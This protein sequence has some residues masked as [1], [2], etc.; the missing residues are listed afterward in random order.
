VEAGGLTDAAAPGR[1]GRRVR[2]GRGGATRQAGG[3]KGGRTEGVLDE[4]RFIARSGQAVTPRLG[5]RSVAAA[6]RRGA[7][8]EAGLG[9]GFWRETSAGAPKTQKIPGSHG[10][11]G[12]HPSRAP[13]RS[14][15]PVLFFDNLCSTPTRPLPQAFKHGPHAL[16]PRPLFAGRSSRQHPDPIPR[17]HR[18]TGVRRPATAPAHPRASEREPASPWFPARA[19]PE[20][21]T[22][23]E[24]CPS[25][26]ISDQLVPVIPAATSWCREAA[27]QAYR[28]SKLQARRPATSGSP[29]NGPSFV[30]CCFVPTVSLC[31]VVGR[32]CCPYPYNH[33]A[34]WCCCLEPTMQ[35][36]RAGAGA[37]AVSLVMLQL[38]CPSVYVQAF[39]T[40]NYVNRELN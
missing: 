34:A 39:E 29:T 24:P 21:Q 23:D 6:A 15:F 36:N 40:L 32:V 31:S 20:I 25:P 12:R 27:L 14:C 9:G 7:R 33:A 38:C 3:R 22:A 16:G 2:G 35:H 11:A 17:R 30:P 28:S 8:G 19:R 37:A 5:F 1:H 4:R 18:A 26:A 10:R 13:C